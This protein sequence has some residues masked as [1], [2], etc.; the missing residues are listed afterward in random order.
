METTFGGIAHTSLART[1]RIADNI[2]VRAIS[3]P[4]VTKIVGATVVVV[5]FELFDAANFRIAEVVGA[6]VALSTVDFGVVTET[7]VAST[8]ETL[9]GGIAN[10]LPLDTLSCGVV[11]SG[12]FARISGKWANDWCVHTSCLWIAINVD[13]VRHTTISGA[14]VVVVTV[15]GCCL[16]VGICVVHHIQAVDDETRIVVGW[17]FWIILANWVSILQHTSSVDSTTSGIVLSTLNSIVLNTL[18]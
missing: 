15:D 18:S 5:A 14:S 13:T 9:V 8:N 17:A 1:C 12:E 16:A 6:I 11:A 7:I 4:C 10:D 3:V 2:G